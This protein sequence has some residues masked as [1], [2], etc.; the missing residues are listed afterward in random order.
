[1]EQVF[2]AA[3]TG[4]PVL[5]LVLAAVVVMGSPGPAT[6]SVTAIGAAFGFRR[7]LSYLSGI[8]LGTSTVLLA[9]SVGIVS[10]LMSLPRLAPMLLTASAVYILYLAFRI[11]TAP[12]LPVQSADANAPSF[13]GGF[14]LGVANPKAYVAI[15]AVF[16]GSTLPIEP[17]MFEA[18]IKTAILGFM[19]VVIHLCWL[20]AGTSL[21]RFL[22]NPVYSRAAN[23]S[24]AAILIAATVVPM[25]G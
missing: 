8:I 24:F 17:R 21:S 22:R 7:S 25:V 16:T 9:V 14:L 18:L 5:T 19:I 2:S 23:L 11:A 1:M 6:M 10:L 15:A 3:D 13:G 4:R 20:L 12:P